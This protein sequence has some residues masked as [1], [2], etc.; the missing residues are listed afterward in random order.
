MKTRFTVMHLVITS[1]AFDA[2]IVCF[3]YENHHR[4]LLWPLVIFSMCTMFDSVKLLRPRM[5]SEAFVAWSRLSPRELGLG[6][7]TGSELC[8]S[9]SLSIAEKFKQSELSHTSCKAFAM[10]SNF[11]CF[12]L[13]AR[14]LYL[15]LG[16]EFSFVP[17]FSA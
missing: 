15:F 1:C 14:G 16:E 4:L 6:T 11:S 17:F 2:V 10:F 8:V 12:S 13:F 9:S 5:N 3:L 7:R